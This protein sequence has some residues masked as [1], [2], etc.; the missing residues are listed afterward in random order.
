MNRTA[1][2]KDVWGLDAETC[3]AGM[4][5]CHSLHSEEGRQ[6]YA[7]RIVMSP[8]VRNDKAPDKLESSPARPIHRFGLARASK[9]PGEDE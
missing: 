3:D 4:V 5:S 8:R 1:A 7:M 9:Q 6:A 2:R